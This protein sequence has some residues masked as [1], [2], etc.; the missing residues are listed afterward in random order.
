MQEESKNTVQK[1]D[2]SKEM[3]KY[4]AA[5]VVCFVTFCGCILFFF[6]LY[7]YHGFTQIWK[8]IFQVLQPIIFGLVIAYLINP[9]M[10]FL[11]KHT[12][13]FIKAQYDE[14]E[15][16]IKKNRQI[17]KFARVLGVIGAEV[18]LILVIFLLLEMMIPELMAS[19]QNMVGNL[20]AEVRSFGKQ[21]DKYFA[22]NEQVSEM[23]QSYLV[24]VTT[25]VEDFVEKSLLPQA[26]TYVTSI[27]TGVIGVAKALVNILV[28]LIVSI[29]LLF[30]KEVFIAQ[31]KKVLY[32]IMPVK[33]GNYVLHIVNISNQR[34]GGF[35]SG[36]ILDSAIIGVLC[37]LGLLVLK[38]P[39]S[40]LVAVIVGVT[41]V[42]PFF[43]PYIGAIPSFVLIALADPMKGISFVIFVLVLQQVDGNIIGPKILGDSTGLSAF[44]VV[45]AIMVGG[46]LFGFLGMLLGVPA[47]A[48]VYDLIKENVAMVLEKK[49]LPK[50]TNSYRELKSINAT[51]GEITYYAS[52]EKQ[53]KKRRK[54][55][56]E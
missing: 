39:Y 55:K 11:E 36:K 20:P 7:R 24:N 25:Y 50:N 17:D 42:I 15:L 33:A 5:A 1:N 16:S 19:I 28:G 27:T 45:F 40:M 35:I 29:Y 53:E 34:F 43:G 54:Q 56:T 47:F 14:K 8:K 52:G 23:I 32:A 4:I 48:V 2:L 38:M 12:S 46:G 21:L 3:K 22:N 6:L 44:W 10:M 41:N 13:R 49:H 18:F 9:I 31:A 26:N 51:S 30:S 37:Y